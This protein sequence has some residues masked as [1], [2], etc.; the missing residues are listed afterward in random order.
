[1][2]Y[3]TALDSDQAIAGGRGREAMLNDPRYSSG[4]RLKPSRRTWSSRSRLVSKDAGSGIPR[5]TR[6]KAA[7]KVDRRLANDSY[8]GVWPLYT[9]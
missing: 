1:M 2:N 6:P 3:N 8:N 7:Y 4:S 9:I 5:R